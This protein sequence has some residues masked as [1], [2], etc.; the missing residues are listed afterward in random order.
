MNDERG[1]SPTCFTL[2]VDDA[3][4]SRDTG[5]ERIEVRHQLAAT[6][7]YAVLVDIDRIGRERCRSQVARSP[8][9]MAS[10]SA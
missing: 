7:R 8:T 1:V 5:G 10:T 4:L 2:V 3:Y 9:A 6:H